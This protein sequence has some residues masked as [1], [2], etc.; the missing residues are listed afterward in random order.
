MKS[1]LRT[2][3]VTNGYESAIDTVVG[4][5][6]LRSLRVKSKSASAAFIFI[7]DMA[8]DPSPGDAPHFAPIPLAASGYYESDTRLDFVYGMHIAISSTE[9]TFTAIVSD[10]F[11]ISA[12]IN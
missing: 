2:T 8:G 12:Q 7:F 1:E 10:D 4:N 9:E 11:F 6:N 3:A 5:V